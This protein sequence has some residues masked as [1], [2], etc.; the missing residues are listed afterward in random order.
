MSVLDTLSGVSDEFKELE[1]ARIK[2]DVINSYIYYP[3]YANTY[4][5]PDAQK[6]FAEVW[7]KHSESL[8][9][10]MRERFGEIT[11]AK[12]LDVAT[13]R[14]VLKHH[15]DTVLHSLWF[16][17]VQIPEQISDFYEVVAYSSRL[18]GHISEELARDAMTFVSTVKYEP[19][20]SELKY[21]IKKAT[22]LFAG[23]PAID[24]EMTDIEGNP[25]KLSDFKGRL[26]YVD[27]WATWCGPCLKEAPLFEALAKRYEG[28]DIVFVPIG[29]DT[30]RKSGGTFS[31]S[32]RRSC[33]SIIPPMPS[34][35]RTGPLISSHVSSSS[36]RISGSSM[37]MHPDHR[38][39]LS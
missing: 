26:I 37:P 25:R 4:T 19:F 2:A 27:L 39:R 17:G 6:L 31:P 22:K 12:Y 20:A 35:I 33:H 16:E 29:T 18:K 32:I 10:E 8:A 30:K 15:Q 7:Q 11:N 23:E 24:I 1:S 34:C 5:G 38:K 9:E 21:S 36:T 3:M 28:K 14:D 13:V